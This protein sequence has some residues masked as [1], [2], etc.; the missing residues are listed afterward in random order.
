MTLPEV[1]RRLA[2]V[3]SED[4][5]AVLVE[6][7]QTTESKKTKRKLLREWFNLCDALAPWRHELREQFE[8]AG[9]VTDN[10]I[11]PKAPVLVYRAAWED[12]DVET[13]LSWTTDRAI[14][15]RFCM[16]LVSPRARFLGIYRDDVE[17][18]IW[19]GICTEM[20]GYLMGRDESEVIAKTVI[21]IQPIATLVKQATVSA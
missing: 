11:R 12:D 21:D 3:G 4:R 9:F 1:E 2:L 17:A 5:A 7:L 18:Y 16:G 6:A 20:L 8:L 19:Q 13:S 14:A 10:H 15:E